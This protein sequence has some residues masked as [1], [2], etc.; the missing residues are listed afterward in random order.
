MTWDPD[1][2][3][4]PQSPLDR[5]T[6]L[7]FWLRAIPF[8]IICFGSLG[9]LLILRQPER[10]IYGL[11]RPYTPYITQ[12]VCRMFFRITGMRLIVRGTPMEEHG[13]IVANHASWTDIFTLHA[14]KRV[15][16]VSKAEV[17]G[18]FGIGWLARATGTI[19]I[20]RVRGEAKQQ[21]EILRDRLSIGHKLLFFPE[22]TSTDAMRVLPFKT[23]L[24]SA[25][26]DPDLRS[27]LKIQPVT[28]IYHA[29]EGREP[30]FYGW[31]GEMDFGW[32]LVRVLGAPRQGSVELV[33]H[34]PIRVAD[35]ADRK[36]LAR[37]CE[38]IV[39]SAMPP[40]RQI[41]E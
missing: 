40:E 34:P 16:Y 24:F 9:L 11:H 6:K 32:H 22:G 39:R 19:F 31:W 5:G 30:T 3:E 8:G 29:P 17:R 15:Y 41:I 10:W 35:Y 38:R 1:K 33:Y 23:T 13:A 14:A 37:E 21:Q 26:Y 7:R 36:V 2:A 28:M 18:W 25:F 4:A 27:M 12:F 20:N